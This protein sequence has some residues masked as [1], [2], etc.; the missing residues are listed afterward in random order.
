MSFERLENPERRIIGTEMEYWA[1]NTQHPSEYRWLPNG[2]LIYTDMGGLECASPETA[3]I[4]EATLY[5]HANDLVVLQFSDSPRIHRRVRGYDE[6]GLL[7][8]RGFHI[9]LEVASSTS[10]YAIAAELGS[11]I[12]ACSLFNG[13]GWA[14][15]DP[16]GKGH[17]GTS[18]RGSGITDVMADTAHNAQKPWII[19]REEN[20]NGGNPDTF[21]LQVTAD[22]NINPCATRTTLA[23]MSIGLRLCEN[24]IYPRFHY[25]DP[26]KASYLIA[27]EKYGRIALPTYENGLLTPEDI[28]EDMLEQAAQHPQLLA[29]DEQV[30]LDGLI[31]EVQRYRA[32]PLSL[33]RRIDHVA[34]TYL[35]EH[36]GYGTIETLSALDLA[37]DTLRGLPN[38]TGQGVGYGLHARG[39][40][41]I[42]LSDN[43]LFAACL[44]PPATRAQHRVEV[45]DHLDNIG[46]E[47]YIDWDDIRGKNALANKEF[48]LVLSSARGVLTPDERASLSKQIGFQASVL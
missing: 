42:Q 31:A 21:R 20:H 10:R 17:F 2:G 35:A 40:F 23:L 9:N 8:L 37:Y 6:A 22:P 46:M 39:N 30:M 18:Q 41:D 19:N 34:K 45:I 32:D 4:D 13:A 3:G 1:H 28:L 27:R 12:T 36:K 44:T 33:W 38:E 15:G 11:F 47:Y 7:N 29:N 25:K 16:E 5:T 43:D 26:V 48:Y 24:G 14:V